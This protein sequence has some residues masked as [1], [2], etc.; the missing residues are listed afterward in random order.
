MRCRCGYMSGAKCKWFAC[1]PADA[2]FVK[3]Q[4]GSAFLVPAYPGCPGKE[5]IKWLLLFI[6]NSIGC[7][8]HYLEVTWHSQIN[9]DDWIFT[10][11]RRN[12]FRVLN[13]LYLR[14]VRITYLIS[15]ELS[16][17]WSNPAAIQ[18]DLL[19]SDWSQPPWTGLRHSA[20]SSDEWGKMRWDE[21]SNMNTVVPHSET[22]WNC[23]CRIFAPQVPFKPCQ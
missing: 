22:S 10:W 9:K 21:M 18:H 6:I 8:Y 3:I 19:C 2:C 1:G 5:A 20:L 11:E 12:I 14:S 17:L 23:K 16:S 7:A 4:N 15:S 13:S